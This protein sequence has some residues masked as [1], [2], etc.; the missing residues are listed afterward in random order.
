MS[1]WKYRSYVIIPIAATAAANALAAQLDPDTGG[2]K[3]FGD[4]Q[5]SASGQLPATHTAC[6]T[7]LKDTGKAGVDQYLVGGAIPGAKVYYESDGWDW[8]K[9]LADS[10]LKAI[11]TE[12]A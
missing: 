10:G 4:V 12:A 8:P 6:S 1:Q 11:D 3:T 2:D 9:C 5:L 7:M